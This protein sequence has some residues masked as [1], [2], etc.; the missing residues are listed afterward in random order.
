MKNRILNESTPIFLKEGY[1]S[2]KIEEV[3]KRL[4]I[5]KKT[6]YRHFHNKERLVFEVLENRKK[7]FFELNNEVKKQSKNALEHFFVLRE[8]VCT[9]TSICQQ[10]KNIQELKEYR[11]SLYHKAIKDLLEITS[12]SFTQI[13][14]R[15]IDEGIFEA[16]FDSKLVGK[17]YAHLFLRMRIYEQ[18]KSEKEY[19]KHTNTSSLIFIRGL[20]TKKG[21]EI[22]NQYKNLFYLN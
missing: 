22:I 5:S 8:Q 18:F 4:E 16:E 20:L 12:T 3:T 15:G 21:F 10:K 13:H 17:L 9:Y 14:K 11:E 2:V 7:L 6:L 1:K 19:L